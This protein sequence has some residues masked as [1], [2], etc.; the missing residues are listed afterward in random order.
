MS[1]RLEKIEF[2]HDDQSAKTD[3]LNIRIDRNTPA[4]PW[5]AGQGPSTAAYALAQTD[6]ADPIT[7]KVTFSFTDLS[8]PPPGGVVHVRGR[9]VPASSKVLG[10]IAST[11]VPFPAAPGAAASVEVVLPLAGVTIWTKGI[12]RYEVAWIWEAQWSAKGAWTFIAQSD[13]IV[14]VTLDVPELPWSQAT[15]AQ[16]APV[17]P[18]TRALDVAC[19]WAGGTTITSGD[20]DGA[21]SK[22]AKKIE[23]RLYE[24]GDRPTPSLTYDVIAVYAMSDANGI[25][26]FALSDFLTLV[27]GTQPT[28]RAPHVNCTD[29]AAALA[30]LSNVL[31]CGLALRR[32]QR[33]D[34]MFAE[35][36]TNPVVPVGLDP[37]NPARKRFSCH[38]VTVR[39]AKA[40]GGAAHVHD[41]CL[42]IDRD[43]DPSSSSPAD[44]QLS[45]GLSLGAFQ[46]LAPRRYI[47]RLIEDAHRAD[48]G[49]HDLGLPSLDQPL[50]T[51]LAPQPVLLL[52]NEFRTRIDEV[53]PR[54]NADPPRPA[55]DL[56]AIGVA[57]FYAYDRIDNPPNLAV[58]QGLITKS[59]EF[60][61]VATRKPRRK[62]SK[63]DERLKISIGYAATARHGRDAL[64]WTLTQTAAPPPVLDEG[65]K[66]GDAA[67]G[68]TG[69]RSAYVVRERALAR[70]V[71][72]GRDPVPLL[73]IARIVDEALKRRGNDALRP[74]H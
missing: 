26:L 34:Q 42:M 22:A 21:A 1:I 48:C 9:S 23:K 60:S 11:S 6:A 66:V 25:T 3:G 8:N 41:A 67:F 70:I 44:Y 15:D 72:T 65:T 59:A 73:P 27:E 4:S 32:L 51:E 52:W 63:R 56:S 50:G 46:S 19:V 10:T 47:H 29:M 55:G 49:S 39:L 74:R 53:S 68:G 14:Y 5:L 30:S 61:Y 24:L 17:W 69:L 13:H 43:P 38:D 71:S 58:L 37:A 28:A 57:G 18:W 2:N 40:G 12:G 35:F 64:A 31:G 20:L 54:I 62:G 36:R 7:I 45:K 16:H 33:D